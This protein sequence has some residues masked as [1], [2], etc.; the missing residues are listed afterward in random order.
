[1]MIHAMKKLDEPVEQLNVRLPQSTRRVIAAISALTGLTQESMLLGSVK[2]YYGIED[3]ETKRIRELCL[4]TLKK[5]K[6][7]GLGFSSPLTP[8]D[9]CAVAGADNGIVGVAG[10]S[11]A[12]STIAARDCGLGGRSTVDA[13]AG[14]GARPP[15]LRELSVGGSH[16]APDRG[17]SGESTRHTGR[18]D[19]ESGH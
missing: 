18:H 11:P 8:N 9:D 2:Y 15:P 10:S 13:E 4:G 16:Q 3:A 6:E 19:V 1:M 5:L 14:P 7:G 17:R 12:D